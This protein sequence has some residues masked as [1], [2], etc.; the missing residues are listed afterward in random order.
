MFALLLVALLFQIKFRGILCSIR[1]T[2]GRN[3]V[4]AEQILSHSN[5]KNYCISY[6]VKKKISMTENTSTHPPV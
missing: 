4:L 6:T 2:P 3:L 5:F 1:K